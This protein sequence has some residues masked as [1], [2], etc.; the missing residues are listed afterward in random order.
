MALFHLL[1]TLIKIAI[2][3]C[4]YATLT[5]VAFRIIGH[6]KPQSWFYRVSR[7]KWRLWFRSGFFISVG[8]FV[9]MC[10]HFGNHGFG[11]SARV[12]VGHGRA[13]QEIDGVRAY[14]Q[15]QDIAMLQVDRFAVTDDYVYG[16]TGDFNENYEG[17]FFVYDLDNNTV[18]T[19]SDQKY[20]SFLK[21]KGL[22]TNPEYKDFRYYYRQY[23]GG[24]RFW[25]LP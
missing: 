15:E 3:A 19:F 12:P 22:E 6:D 11:D 4:L 20:L 16:L 5:L 1:F 7:R 18:R 10:T 14:I 17:N 23:W 21:A 8:L 13:I 2:L 24:W 9:F 25:L